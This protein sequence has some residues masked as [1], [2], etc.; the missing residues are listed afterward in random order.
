MKVIQAKILDPTHL[1]LSQP[2]SAPPG[3]IIEISVVDA[4]EEDGTW[5]E[6][7]ALRFIDAYDDPDSIYDE[8]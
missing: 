3:E 4:G 2:V 7:A 5:R 1:E 8:L 6:A